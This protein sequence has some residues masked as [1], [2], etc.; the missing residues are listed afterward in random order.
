MHDGNKFVVAGALELPWD[1]TYFYMLSQ[2]RG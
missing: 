2:T 1:Q